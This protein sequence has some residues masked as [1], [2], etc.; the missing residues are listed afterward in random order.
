MYEGLK[1]AW[2]C[3]P[4]KNKECQK[5]YC[6]INGGPCRCTGNISYRLENEKSDTYDRVANIIDELNDIAF[7]YLKD[8]DARALMGCEVRI[9]D[10][11]AEK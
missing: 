2:L 9:L 6:F 7:P 10:E 11:V 5:T 4:E 3:D 1:R 8:S